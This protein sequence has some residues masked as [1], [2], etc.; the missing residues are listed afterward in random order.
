M[1]K[2]ETK[3]KKMKVRESEIEDIN[4]MQQIGKT[5]THKT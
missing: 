2:C 4:E 3:K 5:H 1:K